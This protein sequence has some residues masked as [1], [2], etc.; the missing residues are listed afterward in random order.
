MIALSVSEMVVL[1]LIPVLALVFLWLGGS[2][3]IYLLVR[4]RLDFDFK[5]DLLRKFE[6]K[7]DLPSGTDR[8][9]LLYVSKLLLGD[10]CIQAVFLYRISHFLAFHRMR[11]L[12][13]MVHAFSRFATHTDISP[14]AI[15]GRGFYLYHGLGTAIG[16]NTRIGQ[17]VVV[18]HGVSISGRVTIGD[19]V[20][21]W[22]GAQVFPRVTIGN[23]SDVGANAVVLTDYSD[24]SI[25]FGVPAR[26]VARRSF[27]AEDSGAAER[28][29]T[30]GSSGEAQQARDVSHA[31]RA[32]G[33]TH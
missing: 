1:Y 27:F 9:S 26:L 10:S 4:S 5:Y 2:A 6:K 28:D 31:T 21:V 3:L 20:N 13:Q 30:S 15:I 22:P 8:L 17:R 11:T 23:R 12:A 29:D 19:D 25:I 7:R 14:Y 18:C 33:V 16:K 32:R 24:D